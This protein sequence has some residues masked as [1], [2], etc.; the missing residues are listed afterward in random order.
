[1]DE[2]VTGNRITNTAGSGI[3]LVG[4]HGAKVAGNT[5]TNSTIQMKDTS[6]PAAGIA[7]NG[8]D[9]AQILDNTIQSDGIGGIA[10]ATTKDAVIE[11]NQIHDSPKWG[12]HLRVSQLHTTIRHNTIDGAPV[13]VLMEH[14]PADTRL[15]DNSLTRVN[16]PVRNNP[17]R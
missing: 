15:Q 14:N 17:A 2:T 5:I 1:L 13:G 3:Y 7:L 6:L 11:G 12:I 16:Q 8:V 10:L 9:D 4:V